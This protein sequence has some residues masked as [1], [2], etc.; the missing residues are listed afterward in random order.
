MP[1]ILLASRAPEARDLGTILERDHAM[2]VTVRDGS[3]T[4]PPAAFDC[5]VYDRATADGALAALLD[6]DGSTPAVWLR[7][8]DGDA[9]SVA[10]AADAV[11]ERV[12]A[13][14]PDE[15][16][17]W[18]WAESETETDD[19]RDLVTNAPEPLVVIDAGTG[20]LVEANRA[21]TRLLSR[22]RADLIGRVHAEFHPKG[23]RDEYR[24][25]L[26]EFVDGATA[27][28]P[29]RRSATFDV[30]DGDGNEIPV[31]VGA[32]VV[33]F[34][35]GTAVCAILH[36]ATER[37]EQ[38]TEIRRQRDRLSELDRINRVIRDIV[39]LLVGASTRAGIEQGVCDRLAAS[40]SYRFAWIGAENVAT[41]EIEPRAWAGVANEYLDGVTITTD[42]GPTGRGPSGRAYRTG[43][44]AVAQ[45]LNEDPEFAPWS[46]DAL[47]R[48]YRS[49][50]AIPLVYGD[51]TYGVLNLY[52]SRPNAFDDRETAVLGELGETI[53]HAMN[54]V[55]SKRLFVSDGATELDVRIPD[56]GT[57]FADASAR[58]DCRVELEG[59]VSRDDGPPIQFCTVSRA[60][61]DAIA[62]LASASPAIDRFEVVAESDGHA[63]L[64][65]VFRG[66]SVIPVLADHGARTERIVAEGGEVRVVAVVP[67]GIDVRTV[68]EA[69]TRSFPSTE[70]VA[71]REVD[72]PIGTDEAFRS[73]VH[74]RLTEKQRAALRTAHL[75]GF[76]EW[77]RV[78]TGEEVA[79]RLDVSPATFHQ[80]LRVG[81]NKL[82][83]VLFDR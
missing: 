4:P 36:D 42:E 28:G 13:T 22:S 47:A 16:D 64:K 75:S 33:E 14:L 2:D 25:R 56:A 17:V 18:S 20:E 7:R 57:F 68:V 53:G 30:I 44:V 29:D 58:L 67:H 65:F 55:E 54:A 49:S 83:N 60:S 1:R 69:F 45:R 77:P 5:L 12:R 38:R 10:S 15:M 3:E 34:R 41:A 81:E 59:T 43:S 24:R 62:D 26:R 21:A 74:D 35:G 76:F 39:E 32:R 6:D 63:L 9:S 78:S 73:T 61:S 51:A 11:A 50:A 37:V 80:H 72:R 40:D 71:Q 27:D 70:L 52:A 48:G 46:E 31:D 79:E 8:L 82:I 66:R 23:E 19:Y